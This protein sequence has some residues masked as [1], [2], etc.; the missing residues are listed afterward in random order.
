MALRLTITLIMLVLT[1]AIAGRRIVWLVRLIRS[2]RPTPGRLDGIGDRLRAELVEVL[3][4]R[5][6]LKW[7]V[8]GLAHFF[9]FWG[10]IVL[11]ITVVESF[12]AAVI[13]KDF[14]FPFVGHARWLGFLEDFFAVAV[15]IALCAFAIM[16]VRQ[17]P[18]RRQRSS[19]F[20]GSHT[21]P[22]WVILGMITLVVVTLL[23]YR[24]AQYNTGHFPW[25]TSKAPFASYVVAKAL[26]TG[27][28]NQG[29]ETFFVLGQMAVV[30]GFTILVVYS[31]HLHIATAPINVS[32]KRV[33]DGLGP[34]LPVLDTEGKPID[35]ADAEN[36]SEDTLFGKG[37]IEDFGWK[38]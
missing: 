1:A 21:R 10:F 33:P 37:K 7:S 9:T 23:L 14:A 15:L 12:G 5:K 28:Y 26:G 19:R 30:L 34:L 38:G 31:K 35:F 3:G 6:L 8:P 20:Y 25:G 22:A 13:S 2:G 24:G 4:Q 36:L 18:A 16:R 17:A 32:T 27:A 29:V 11:G